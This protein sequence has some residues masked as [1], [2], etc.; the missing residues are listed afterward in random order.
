MRSRK[1][2]I[3]GQ[4]NGQR[5]K[6]KRTNNDI[7]V[8]RKQIMSMTNTGAPEEKPVPTPLIHVFFTFAFCNVSDGWGGGGGR[9]SKEVKLRCHSLVY[10]KITY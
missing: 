4:Y 7:P 5:K 2:K 10:T 1:S 3:Y 6:D 8:H 9:E